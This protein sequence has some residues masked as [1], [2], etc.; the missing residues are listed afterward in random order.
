MGTNLHQ[1]ILDQHSF[2]AQKFQKA[3][4]DQHMVI[5]GGASAPSLADADMLV[6]PYG[7]SLSATL[8]MAQGAHERLRVVL[9][10]LLGQDHPT[11][12][13][14]SDIN[15]DLLERET[16]LEDYNPRDKGLEA[17]LPASITH[18]VHIRLSYWFTRKCERRGREPFPD[19]KEL[20]RN[21]NI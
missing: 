5:A 12:L 11:T 7:L 21:M 18:W 6:A 8:T 10:T 20:W 2:L 4:T 14:M 17:F 1:S 13:A 16:E 3:R 19:L 9:I 15:A